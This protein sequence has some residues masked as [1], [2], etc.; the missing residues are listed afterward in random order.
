MKE[1]DQEVYAKFRVS[2]DNGFRNEF[3]Y[4][5][6]S[7]WGIIE[8]WAAEATRPATRA[9]AR[10]PSRRRR[11]RRDIHQ[12]SKEAVMHLR[13]FRD[14][15]DEELEPL[16][17]AG[18]RAAYQAL[19]EHHIAE[20]S[21]L[22]RRLHNM[23]HTPEERAIV[24]AAPWFFDIAGIVSP[25]SQRGFEIHPGWHGI[26]KRL[27]PLLERAAPAARCTQCKEKF[28]YL[29]VYYWIPP[30]TPDETRAIV[31]ALIDAAETASSKTCE[32]CGGDGELIQESGWWRVRCQPCRNKRD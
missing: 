11:D 29:R 30:E 31:R 27:A 1:R 14:L 32:M 16:D 10:V 9:P 7:R 25:W 13:S 6:Y 28:G 22:W 4:V 8:L 5:D 2:V 23:R 17:A 26:V 24:R 12:A 20:T 19:R 15:S 18:L 21:E 3:S